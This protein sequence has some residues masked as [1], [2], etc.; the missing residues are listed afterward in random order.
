[1]CNSKPS[2][3]ICIGYDIEMNHTVSFGCMKT[4]IVGKQ[5]A[6]LWFYQESSKSP[7]VREEVY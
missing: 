7:R 5:V 3:Y 1:M 4:L 6:F 2:H